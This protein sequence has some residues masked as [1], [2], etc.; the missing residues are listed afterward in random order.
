MFRRL[1]LSACAAASGMYRELDANEL[2]AVIQQD[3]GETSTYYARRYFGPRTERRLTHLLWTDLKKRGFV[4][5]QRGSDPSAQPRWYACEAVP[6]RA[7]K[8]ARYNADD[9]DLSVLK[10]EQ[11]LGKLQENEVVAELQHAQ[12]TP[13]ARSRVFASEPSAPH[14]T[15]RWRQDLQ[16]L[17]QGAS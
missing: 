1:R 9:H 13:T 10:L 15:S 11:D 14:P 4:D 17:G 2:L 7:P 6:F 3:G 8:V 16:S 5:L 12:S